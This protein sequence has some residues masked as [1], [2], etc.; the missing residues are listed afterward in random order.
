LKRTRRNELLVEPPKRPV[1][2]GRIFVGVCTFPVLKVG[3]QFGGE[4]KG[5]LLFRCLLVRLVVVIIFHLFLGFFLALGSAG[6]A[7]AFSFFSVGGGVYW[8]VFSTN[9]VEPKIEVR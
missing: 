2:A 5:V 6:A 7:G 9:T 4:V 1:S 8:S 3:R